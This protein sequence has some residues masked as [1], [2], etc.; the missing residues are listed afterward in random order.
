M[1]TR[2]TTNSH[3]L[4]VGHRVESPDTTLSGEPHLTQIEKSTLPVTAVRS[5]AKGSTSRR[6]SAP[7]SSRNSGSTATR[8][9]T[10]QPPSLRVLLLWSRD[11]RFTP[12]LPRRGAVRGE[13]HRPSRSFQ[14]RSP[15]PLPEDRR[16]LRAIAWPR[17][18]RCI[19]GATERAARAGRCE[20]EQIR[21]RIQHADVV[22]IDETGIKR[23]GEQAWMWTFTTDE[24][25]LYAV[26]ESRGSDVP[27]EVL[28][29]GLRGN[30]RLRW[31][32]GISGIH[33]QPPAVL[34]TYSPRSGRCR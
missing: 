15:P 6:A 5:V 24:H 23:D 31:L 29:E 32:D 11:C 21:R 33:Q 27:A 19:C 25:T 18:L 14:I 34:G 9:Y 12:R 17:T 1:R 22:H 26:R 2:T 30:G 4:T 20:Y 16:P 7:D 3:V 8:S 13:R 28:G 10:V